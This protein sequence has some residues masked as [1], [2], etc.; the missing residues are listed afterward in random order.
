MGIACQIQRNPLGGIEKVLDLSGKESKLFKELSDKYGEPKALDMWSSAYTSS[1]AEYS[2]DIRTFGIE[3]TVLE[4]E[5]FFNDKYLEDISFSS[6]ERNEVYKALRIISKESAEE[7]VNDLFRLFSG[8]RILTEKDLV[9]SGYYTTEEALEILSNP[10]ILGAVSLNV[11]K[12]YLESIKDDNFLEGINGDTED[13]LVYNSEMNILGNKRSSLLN[14]VMEEVVEIATTSV[15]EEDFLDRVKNVT[16]TEL[17]EAID[18]NLTIRQKILDIYQTSVQSDIMVERNGTLVKIDKK[19]Q[20]HRGVKGS[21]F[22]KLYGTII[23]PSVLFK[24]HNLIKS[25]EGIY[26][27]VYSQDS[28]ESI[29]KA[30]HRRVSKLGSAEVFGQDYESLDKFLNDV[31]EENRPNY[32]EVYN[33]LTDEEITKIIWISKIFNISLQTLGD[34]IETEIGKKIYRQ[35]KGLFDKDM[36]VLSFSEFMKNSENDIY[37]NF[38]TEDGVLFV[39]E[40]APLDLKDRMNVSIREGLMESLKLYGANENASNISNYFDYTYEKQEVDLNM[41]RELYANKPFLLPEYK[42]EKIETSEGYRLNTNEVF[43]KI[44]EKLYENNG[45]EF[46]PMGRVGDGRILS[47][48]Y[49]KSVKTIEESNFT[50][51]DELEKI[52]DEMDSCR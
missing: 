22:V 20:A 19:G 29:K 34:D 37:D 26:L 28:L 33:E 3:P 24:E 11:R 52:D 13:I 32:Q 25:G 41:Q 36:F 8:N 21:K 12:L 46:L 5:G 15:N 40:Y 44:D 35:E 27:Q 4:L 47:S 9:D 14:N 42:G 10:R 39:D 6:T 2:G 30:V 17:S 1:F 31:V 18:E 48:E 7:T 16:D 43:V 51:K 38:Y 49:R 23:S 45:I 50:T